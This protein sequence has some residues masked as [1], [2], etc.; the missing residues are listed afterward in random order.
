MVV[1][2]LDVYLVVESLLKR[3][4][5]NLSEGEIKRLEQI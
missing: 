3:N 1:I 2:H 5:G 4:H